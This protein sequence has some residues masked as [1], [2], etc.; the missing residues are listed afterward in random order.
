MKIQPLMNSD[1]SFQGKFVKNNAW[2]NIRRFYNQNDKKVIDGFE[3]YIKLIEQHCPENSVYRFKKNNK[4]SETRGF[5]S[6]YT[7]TRND[8]PIGEES[9]SFVYSL[10]NKVKNVI[11]K[12]SV[13]EL[14]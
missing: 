13:A 6:T 3:P 14:E 2:Y 5:H 4:Y 12:D 1:T 10:I 7:L 8:K 11:V 9:L